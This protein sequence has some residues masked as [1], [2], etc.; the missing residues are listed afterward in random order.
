MASKRE[1]KYSYCRE[2]R[3]QL[4]IYRNTESFETQSKSSGYLP[5]YDQ[6]KNCLHPINFCPVSSKRKSNIKR[7]FRNSKKIK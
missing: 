4:E 6:E 7:H 1:I 3:M 2:K 5:I